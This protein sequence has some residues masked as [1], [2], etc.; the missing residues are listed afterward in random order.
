M[1]SSREVEN[2]S[3]AVANLVSSIGQAFGLVI[4][5]YDFELTRLRV[6]SA[7]TRRL[8]AQRQGCTVVVPQRLTHRLTGSSIVEYI[9][10]SV[11]SRF[12][13]V[14][15]HVLIWGLEPLFE[16]WY[17]IRRIGSTD[18]VV[19]GMQ[20]L[21]TGRSVLQQRLPCPLIF[22]FAERVMA[23]LASR[24][25][26]FYVWT[27][28][29]YEV[30]LGHAD[31]ALSS[32]T[33]TTAALESELSS[34]DVVPTLRTWC[35]NALSLLECTGADLRR[36]REAS[37]D[38]RKRHELLMAT[39]LYVA[40]NHFEAAQRVA[41]VRRQSSDDCASD[42]VTLRANTLERMIHSMKQELSALH[43]PT[44]VS[45][46]FAG[47]KREVTDICSRFVNRMNRV[48][49]VFGAHGC[50]VSRLL[51]DGVA[52]ALERHRYRV[53]LMH[54]W[55]SPLHD[56]MD[57]FSRS[58]I[59]VAD[60]ERSVREVLRQV[61]EPVIIIC[62]E[63]GRMFDAD[64]KVAER[65]ECL[66]QLAS[67][68]NDL[69][70]PV[71]VI[72]G[73]TATDL[74]RLIEMERELPD[75]MQPRNRY[76]LEHLT[77]DDARDVVNAFFGT[78]PLVTEEFVSEL[79]LEVEKD[80]SVP[81]FALV[82]RLA[83][84]VHSTPSGPL[85][86]LDDEIRLR[87]LK[88][89]LAPS[90]EYRGNMRLTLEV[91]YRLAR[92][93]QPYVSSADVAAFWSASRQQVSNVLN[94]LVRLGLVDKRATGSKETGVANVYGLRER[95]MVGAIERLYMQNVGSAHPPRK[96]FWGSLFSSKRRS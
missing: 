44:S 57:A 66:A 73:V 12:A 40:G 54:D 93:D 68:V 64:I 16:A 43:A 50:G 89:V 94:E 81:A 1:R 5:S 20:A 69:A 11:E 55:R 48:L 18:A 37:R 23:E 62:D 22:M 86:H 29:I 52:P 14:P 71:G 85:E 96:S 25:P 38:V 58:G 17:P 47:R 35:A 46:P 82:E 61:P 19:N 70:L 77:S 76:W 24:C 60:G 45:V 91:L 84:T 87:W 3:E 53:V 75:V 80:G 9:V 78:R 88:L 4:V 21:N 67:C 95:R 13:S 79:L 15:D 7:I 26:D 59:T 63:L 31:Q 27:S 49:T 65:Q 74:F 33:A 34:V 32:I 83:L 6:S 10:A 72:L 2:V 51:K 39:I 42:D 90:P 8:G 56:L 36:L 28:G 30:Q 41:L 92:S